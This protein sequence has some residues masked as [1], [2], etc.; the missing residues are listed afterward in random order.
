MSDS[1]S[2]SRGVSGNRVLWLIDRTLTQAR[3]AVWDIR[4]EESANLDIA[5]ECKDACERIFGGTATLC[6]LKCAAENAA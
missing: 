6:R 3:Q 2:V 4:P 1:T 5:R